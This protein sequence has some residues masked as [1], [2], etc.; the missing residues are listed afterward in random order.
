MDSSK[1]QFRAGEGHALTEDWLQSAK[2][3]TTGA[4]D[5]VANAAQT[6][7]DTAQQRQDET[8]NFFQQTGEQMMNMA[9]GAVDTVKNTLGVADN[10]ITTTNTNTNTRK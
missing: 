6:T 7:M 3:T 8:A 10:N 9:H 1:Q 2:D 4:R 5:N